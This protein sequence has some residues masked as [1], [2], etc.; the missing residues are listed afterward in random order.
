MP[1][2]TALPETVFHHHKQLARGVLQIE[3]FDLIMFQMIEKSTVKVYIFCKAAVAALRKM[4]TFTGK[5]FVKNV[6]RNS[7]ERD[8]RNNAF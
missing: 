7:E 4:N 1:V 2:N 3:L 6:M 8:I 5:V